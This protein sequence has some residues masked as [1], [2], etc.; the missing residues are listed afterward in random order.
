MVRDTHSPAEGEGQDKLAV[1]AVGVGEGEGVAAQ[2]GAAGVA[3]AARARGRHVALVLLETDAEERV[4]RHQGARHGGVGP[5]HPP[6]AL[7]ARQLPPVVSYLQDLQF[8]KSR[9]VNA[10]EK[11]KSD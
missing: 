10:L 8:E 3:E 11:T 6:A 9:P 5:R 7:P 4:T 2:H 1:G